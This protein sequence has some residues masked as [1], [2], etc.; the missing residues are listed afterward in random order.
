M[1]QKNASGWRYEAEGDTDEAVDEKSRR[2]LR[3]VGLAQPALGAGRQDD[4][5]RSAGGE[6]ER[7]QSAGDAGDR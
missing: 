3:Q 6:Q 1:V 2:T 4:D 5:H 7:D